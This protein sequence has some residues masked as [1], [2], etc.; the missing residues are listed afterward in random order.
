MLLRGLSE[1][2]V[3]DLIDSIYQQE[4]TTRGGEEFVRAILRETEG[5]PFF[6]EEVLRHLVE[7]GAFYRRDSRWVSDAKSIAELGIPEGV[8]D[9]IGRRL[10]RLSETCNR[11]LA[12]AAVVGRE[13]EFELLAPMTGL[14]EDEIVQAVDEGLANQMVV[15]TRGRW[16]RAMRSL[17]LWFAR[18]FM[19]S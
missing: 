18:R 3:K 5:N 15:E 17:T 8:R 6:I 12:A 13:F 2:E 9:V 7:S 11:A 14:S 10:S 4:V 16:A 1:P 19:K